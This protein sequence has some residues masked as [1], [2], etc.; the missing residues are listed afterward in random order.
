MIWWN[1]QCILQSL[2]FQTQRCKTK[3]F[4][5]NKNQLSDDQI[6]K[7]TQTCLEEKS[8]TGK[9]NLTFWR[10]DIPFYIPS[11]KKWHL[12]I[13]NSFLSVVLFSVS[14]LKLQ[15]GVSNHNFFCTP[16]N[17]KVWSQCLSADRHLKEQDYCKGQED[18]QSMNVKQFLV[19]ELLELHYRFKGLEKENEN[20][21]SKC[22]LLEQV[23]LFDRKFQV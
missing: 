15:T 12:Y 7:C 21:H 23:R 8:K 13:L 20:M 11:V 4:K 18:L 16:E 5:V 6:V 14:E 19:N 17:H 2:H 10:G 3:A 22:L 1:R 9:E